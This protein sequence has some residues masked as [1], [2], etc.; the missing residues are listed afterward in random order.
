MIASDFKLLSEMVST[1]P[2]QTPQLPFPPPLAVAGAVG[3]QHTVAWPDTF[4]GHLKGGYEQVTP[5]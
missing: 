5:C 3:C 4:A 1:S 2:L